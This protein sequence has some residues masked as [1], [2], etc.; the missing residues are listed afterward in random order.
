MN[1][2]TYKPRIVPTFKTVQKKAFDV[3]DREHPV[4]AE[5][6]GCLGTYNLTAVVEE[7][8][9]TQSSMKHVSGLISFLCTLLKNGKVVSQG[10]GSSV[11]SPSNRF[12]SRAVASAF[13]S[14]VADAAIRATKVLD[15]FRS[16]DGSVAPAVIDEA[17]KARD[18]YE[19]AGITDKQKSYLLELIQTSVEDEDERSR[20]ESQIDD[21]T[22]DEASSAIQSFKR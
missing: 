21:M 10:R 14:A 20:W 18:Q 4:R 22:K 7:D 12:L 6:E 3:Q 13:N 9:Q 17:Y 8:M 1:T 2:A 19:S 5:I 11:L 16:A 15:T